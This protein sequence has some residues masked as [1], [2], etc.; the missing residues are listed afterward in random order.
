MNR[1]DLIDRLEKLTGPVHD[2]FERG[3]LA[4]LAPDII[5]D[6]DSENLFN[7]ALM[8]GLP[9]IGAAVA[10][11][12]RCLPGWSWRCGRSGALRNGWATVNKTHPDFAK[13][14]IDQFS[15]VDVDA[16]SPAVALLIALFR[17]LE[18]EGARDE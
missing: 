14:G 13:P 10:L 2:A 12:E 1:A 18:A 7:L 4:K 16:A 11:V 8:G 17:A 15:S 3:R 5:N 9:A 6:L